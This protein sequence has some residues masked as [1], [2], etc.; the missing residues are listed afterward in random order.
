MGLFRKA[1]VLG[2][3]LY[4]LPSPPP[5]AL[6]AGGQPSLQSSTFATITAAA[7]TVA[8]F[9]G[10]CER[11]PQACI[12]GQYLAYTL[13]AKAKY[14]AR[15]IYEWANP[16]SGDGKL[17]ASATPAPAPATAKS[18]LQPANLRLATLTEAAAKPPSKIEDLLRGTS[19]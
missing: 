17:T 5:E 19:N 18:S 14:S 9:K 4:A 15:I 10:F 6:V 11:R 8:D 3:I 16:N 7:D 12:T 2:G 1:I 13:E